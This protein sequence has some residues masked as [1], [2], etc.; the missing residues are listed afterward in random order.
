MALKLAAILVAVA[1]FA[2]ACTPDVAP[3]TSPAATTPTPTAE[4]VEPTGAPVPVVEISP[5]PARVV[6]PTP[7]TVTVPTVEVVPRPTSPPVPSPTISPTPVPTVTEDAAIM[8]VV[9]RARLSVVRIDV[10]SANGI[11]SGTGFA[12]SAQLVLTNAHVVDGA[13]SIEVS[14]RTSDGSPPQIFRAIVLGTDEITDIAVLQVADADFVRTTFGRSLDVQVGESVFAIGFQPG[15]DGDI[16]ATKG[17]VTRILSSTGPT[18]IQHDARVLP[19]N[20][21]GPLITADGTVIGISAASLGDVTGNAVGALNFALAGEEAA[22]RLESLERGIDE[23]AEGRSFA[24]PRLGHSFDIPDGWG[25]IEESDELTYAYDAATGA[26]IAVYVDSEL[27]AF[28]SG[29]SWASFYKLAGTIGTDRLTYELL[30]DQV[31]S[32]PDGSTEWQY[33]ERFERSG[34]GFRSVR[35]ANF[36][37]RDGLGVRV[38]FEAPEDEFES[39][40]PAMERVLSSSSDPT[41][42]PPGTPATVDRECTKFDADS[43]YVGSIARTTD[44]ADAGISISFVRQ[45]C[46]LTGLVVIEGTSQ[47]GS[48]ALVGYIDG[49]TVAFTVPEAVNDAGADLE[50][51]GT[52]RVTGITGTYSVPGL[53]QRG[54]WSVAPESGSPAFFA[55]TVP[56]ATPPPTSTPTPTATPFPTPTP[57]VTPTPTPLPTATPVPPVVDPDQ[58]SWFISGSLIHDPDSNS[59]KTHSA[60]VD[61]RDFVAEATFTNPYAGLSPNRWEAGIIFRRTGATFDYVVVRSDA[62]W[63]HYRRLDGS[64]GRD[65]LVST[66]FITSKLNVGDEEENRLLLV[67]TGNSGQLIL[68]G[69]LLD[70]LRLRESN[71]KGEVQVATGFTAE[72]EQ[73]GA[74]T[75]FEDFR[76]RG[77]DEFFLYDNDRNGSLRRDS[78]IIAEDRIGSDNDSSAEVTFF[79]P[80]GTSEGSWSYGFSFSTS[81]GGSDAVFIRNDGNWYH[82]RRNSHGEDTTLI[83]RALP[84]IDVAGGSINQLRVLTIGST[85]WLSVNGLHAGSFELTSRTDSDKTKSAGQDFNL[86]AQFFAND[87]HPGIPINY[88]DLKTWKTWEDPDK[89]IPVFAP[90]PIATVVI[91]PT[92]TVTPLGTPTG[93]I[94]DLDVDYGHLSRNPHT[95]RRAPTISIQ[96]S[97]NKPIHQYPIVTLIVDVNADETYTLSEVLPTSDTG[98]TWNFSYTFDRFLPFT[99]D[100]FSSLEAV[101]RWQAIVRG[102]NIGEVVE[103]TSEIFKLHIDQ[104]PPSIVAGWEGGNLVNSTGSVGTAVNIQWDGP[105]KISSLDTLDFRLVTGSAVYIPLE[106]RVT[107]VDDSRLQLMFNQEIVD[108]GSWDVQIVGPIQDKAGN[109]AYTGLFTVRE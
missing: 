79:N 53:G 59:I 69:V 40:F 34:S 61:L 90:T 95:Q 58:D 68:N 8:G 3:T 6:E 84:G 63:V 64:R 71:W 74:V 19:G 28:A 109:S 5:T 60:I 91:A 32:N 65:R 57:T 78:G 108:Q 70:D 17:T 35:A 94:F 20:T 55:T 87:Y 45:G 36:V 51:T 81:G 10:T 22:I 37:Y 26:F 42:T 62:Q 7:G 75:A 107:G 1:V 24:S 21:G 99:A 52:L 106:I 25:F 15:I 23:V 67:V 56:T 77:F 89:G 88:R 46:D 12:Y 102:G 80:Y 33:R 29:D 18:L 11:R 100:G 4:E 13:G 9:E 30:S 73:P 43:D 104:R 93:E 48:G 101:I 97:A 92:A 41:I 86:I 31:V 39:A 54:S 103:I 50:F 16:F 27:P 96:V 66:G 105:L 72:G 44:G 82:V 14:I 85:G 76:V 98:T 38:Y 2:V 47:T 49:R 83:G